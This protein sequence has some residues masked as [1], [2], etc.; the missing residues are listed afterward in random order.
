MA[1]FLK[2]QDKE[3]IEVLNTGPGYFSKNSDQYFCKFLKKVFAE[4]HNCKYAL[5]KPRSFL[6]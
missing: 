5:K 3:K 4:V 1:H 6:K 2:G